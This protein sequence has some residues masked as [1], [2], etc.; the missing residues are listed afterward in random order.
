MQQ[1]IL[2]RDDKRKTGQFYTPEPV[3]EFMINSLNLNPNLKILDSS[4]GCG[5]FLVKSYQYLLKKYNDTSLINNIY[6]VDTN[7]KAIN[8]TRKNLINIA[9]KKYESVIKGNIQLGNSVSGVN[10]MNWLKS[11]P[12]VFS[13]GGFDYIIGNPPYFTVTSKTN[14]VI[15]FEPY[16]NVINGVVNIATLMTAAGYDLLKNNGTLI[17]LLPKSITRVKSYKRLRDFLL[18][19]TEIKEIFDI[20]KAFKEVRGEQIILRFKKKY[21]TKNNISIRKFETPDKPFS[22]Q[23]K[24]IIDQNKYK[25]Y[26]TFLTNVNEVVYTVGNKVL[27]R[28][29]KL[30]SLSNDLIFRGVSFSKCTTSNTRTSMEFVSGNMIDKFRTKNK[31]YLNKSTIYDLPR[32]AKLLLTPKIIIQNI[33]SAESGIKGAYDAKGIITSE[34]VTNIIIDQKKINPK[35]VFAIMN[36]KLL[37]FFITYI[38]FNGSLFTMHTDKEYIGKVPI[39]VGNKKI[40]NNLISCANKIFYNPEC[41]KEF[42]PKVDK[43]VYDLYEIKSSL[44]KQI[45]LMLKNIMSKR[46]Y[47]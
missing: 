38:T 17:F 28:G 43:L 47:W 37:T 6:G 15:N 12:S 11:F 22:R 14:N 25:K 23:P 41:W 31:L 29:V 19:H 35:Y 7:R 44:R 40:Q 24:I 42:M 30:E 1:L 5:V 45:D 46:S 39:A 36:S 9:G 18:K 3:V 27:K 13:N 2:T 16:L 33:Y 8:Q 10:G 20:G 4:C 34:T 32:K 26:G 21:P